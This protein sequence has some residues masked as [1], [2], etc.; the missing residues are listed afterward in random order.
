MIR[1]SLKYEVISERYDLSG[2]YVALTCKIRA[3]IFTL[4]S[5]YGPNE[6]CPS[7]YN[8]IDQLLQELPQDNIIIAGD[9]N[10]VINRRSD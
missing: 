1:N 9:F 4:L 2:N 7:F 6:D 5:I 10:F 8:D 3:K